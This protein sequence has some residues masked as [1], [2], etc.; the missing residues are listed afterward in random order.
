MQREYDAHHDGPGYATRTS[1]VRHH[2]W[3]R[4]DA[5]GRRVRAEKRTICERLPDD[6]AA[7]VQASERRP[8]SEIPLMSKTL[9]SSLVIAIAAA[10]A[11][12]AVYAQQKPVDPYTQ[13]A[14]TGKPDP[15]TDGAKAGKFDAYTDGAKSSTR[16]DLAPKKADPYT[17][18]AKVGKADPYTDGAKT[19][20]PDPYTDGARK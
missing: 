16:S 20:K 2:P 1:G 4:V 6:W 18:G 7:S 5:T 14:K 3:S 13:G 19:G 10:G 9:F 17:D 8:S 11:T 15:Y 12:H